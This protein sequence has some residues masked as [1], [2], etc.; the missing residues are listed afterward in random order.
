MTNETMKAWRVASGRQP[1][2]RIPVGVLVQLLDRREL[3]DS[4]GPAMVTAIKKSALD[5]NCEYVLPKGAKR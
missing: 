5:G 1:T 3:T 2:V 4:L